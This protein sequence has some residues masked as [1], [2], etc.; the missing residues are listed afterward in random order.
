MKR[1]RLILIIVMVCTTVFA[2]AQ[3]VVGN[4]LPVKFTIGLKIAG[5]FSNLGGKEWESGYKPGI[6]GGLF[7]GIRRNRFGLSAEALFS[8]VK[9]TGSGLDFYHAIKANGTNTSL[10]FKDAAD[11]ATHGQF[12]VTYLSIPVLLNI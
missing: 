6:A 10:V 2:Q 8:S 7:A 4:A 5:N 1:N 11:S 9:Y 12:A 3:G